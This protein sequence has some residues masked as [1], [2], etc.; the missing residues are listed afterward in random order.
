MV[1]WSGSQRIPA[2]PARS[3]LRE[4]AEDDTGDG[5]KLEDAVVE[6]EGEAEAPK[7][8]LAEGRA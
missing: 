7:L 6:V 5:P 8:E 1:D 4:D 3:E 2:T